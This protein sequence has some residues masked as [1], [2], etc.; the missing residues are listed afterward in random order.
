MMEQ[1]NNY[2]PT[3]PNENWMQTDD[4][5]PLVN[6]ESDIKPTADIAMD[7]MNVMDPQIE[8]SSH[9]SVVVMNE[10]SHLESED[11][12][13]Y[14]QGLVSSSVTNMDDLEGDEIDYYEMT[15]EPDNDDD[16]YDYHGATFDP[17]IADEAIADGYESTSLE[18]LSA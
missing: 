16:T 7:E 11:V 8:A 6:D 12:A 5:S 15:E 9:A 10:E 17:D 3:F 2:A 4:L 1:D 18:V 14:Q 13:P